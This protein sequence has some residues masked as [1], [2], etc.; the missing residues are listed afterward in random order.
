MFPKGFLLVFCVLGAHS[1]A[2]VKNAKF[3]SC[4]DLYYLYDMSENLNETIAHTIHSMTVQGLRMF[5]PRAT[6]NNQVPTVNHDISDEV[7]FT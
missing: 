4:N 6:E 3:L 1:G 5:N 2:T 7:H